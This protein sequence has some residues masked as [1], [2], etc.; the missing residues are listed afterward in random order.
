MLVDLVD[1]SPLTNPKGVWTAI[2]T[3][4]SMSAG[5]VCHS[6]QPSTSSGPARSNDNHFYINNTCRRHHFLNTYF[7]PG[8]RL[9]ASHTLLYIII[10]TP[11]NVG[12]GFVPLLVQLSTGFFQ[13]SDTTEIQ[14]LVYVN[15]T[16]T[17][18]SL[19]R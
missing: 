13:L 16:I 10:V 18:H 15:F 11:H 6:R 12:A 14:I 19:T 7:I 3:Q 4:M 17:R 5:C 9:R 2:P 8:T 1:W